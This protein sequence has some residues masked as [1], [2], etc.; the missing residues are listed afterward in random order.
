M[1]SRLLQLGNL[2]AAGKLAVLEP[3]VIPVRY[4]A[5][6]DVVHATSTALSTEVVQVRSVVL[7]RTGLPID[8]KLFFPGAGVI[9][10]HAV[11]SETMGDQFR[12]TFTDCDEF[13]RERL[14]AL[15]HGR[16]VSTQC[17]PRFHTYLKAVVREPGHS[18]AAAFV[19]NLSSTGAF[20]R[21]ETLP[22]RG[23]V[24]ELDL[25]FPGMSFTR[26]STRSWCTLPRGAASE[27]SSSVPARPSSRGSRSTWRSFRA[28]RRTR[29]ARSPGSALR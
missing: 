12:A 22:A 3:L 7:P 27:C 2:S 17:S 20:V 6:G 24:V 8:L 23:R 10:Q 28:E 18:K 25:A 19:S 11:V 29:A 13:S 4:V 9:R 5:R 15:L 21:L 26:P 1:S 14:Y 16:E